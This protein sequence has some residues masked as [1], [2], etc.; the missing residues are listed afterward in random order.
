MSSEVRV[1]P[2]HDGRQGRLGQPPPGSI[3]AIGLANLTIAGVQGENPHKEKGRLPAAP[4]CFP[5]CAAGSYGRCERPMLAWGAGVAG[6]EEFG[7]AMSPFQNVERCRQDFPTFSR[8]VERRRA[9]NQRS[10]FS[11]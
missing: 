3:L 5:P 7:I 6:N 8:F 4:L 10:G 11:L 2:L 1:Y 9:N